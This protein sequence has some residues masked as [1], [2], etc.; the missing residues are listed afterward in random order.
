MFQYG[1]E[2]R[3][4]S[5]EKDVSIT[6]IRENMKLRHLMDT[7]GRPIKLPPSGIV[8]DERL[9]STLDVEPGDTVSIKTLSGKIKR[10]YDVKVAGIV[11]QYLGLNAYADIDFLTRLLD[12]EML[13][14]TLLLRVEEEEQE[15]L[16]LW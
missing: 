16:E 2:M 8:I 1:F 4:G 12:S 6:G 11:N 13:V 3:A 7:A 5:R 9:A 10:T 15:L 14:N